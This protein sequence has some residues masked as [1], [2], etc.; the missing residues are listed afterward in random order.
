MST[1]TNFFS[2]FCRGVRESASNLGSLVS[3]RNPY[4]STPPPPIDAFIRAGRNNN[5]RQ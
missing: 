5:I 1:I 2:S 4:P 3:G